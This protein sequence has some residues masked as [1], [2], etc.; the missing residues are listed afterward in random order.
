MGILVKDCPKWIQRLIYKE[1]VLQNKPNLDIINYPLDSVLVWG[2]S[3]QGHSFWSKVSQ[4]VF[5]S[6]PDKQL[7]IYY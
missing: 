4:G 2:K 7:I 1:R 6:L 5:P 3:T